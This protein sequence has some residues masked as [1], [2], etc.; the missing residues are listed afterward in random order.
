LRQKKIEVKRESKNIIKVC[1]REREL[2]T[3]LSQMVVQILFLLLK[4]RLY[5]IKA[6]NH[7]IGGD[8]DPLQRH[9]L[10]VRFESSLYV[11]FTVKVF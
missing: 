9:F 3:K 11:L 6:L 1:E 5:L 10:K 8:K 4:L 7:W 2:S